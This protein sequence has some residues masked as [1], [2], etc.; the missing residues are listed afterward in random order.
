MSVP[1]HV[2]VIQP[3]R[4]GDLSNPSDI[5]TVA[6]HATTF[7]IRG[8]QNTGFGLEDGDTVF[9][10]LTC[11]QFTINSP[12]QTSPMSLSNISSSTTVVVLP[13]QLETTVE[14]MTRTL[15]ACFATG[16]ANTSINDYITL[17]D[18]LLI[19]PNPRLGQGGTI[20]AV[21]SS[22]AD[23]VIS[24][25]DSG[26]RI[27]F[28]NESCGTPP[29]SGTS[30]TTVVLN[31]TV[32]STSSKVSLPDTPRLRAS[33]AFTQRTLKACFA[34]A[35]SDSTKNENW[36]ELVD[37]LEVF[38]DPSSGLT[39]LWTQGNVRE[40]SFSQPT[41]NAAQQS[42]IIVL[43]QGSCDGVHLVTMQSA[44][45]TTSAPIVLSSGAIANEFPLAS[46]K[47]N[48]LGVGIFKVCFATGS[49]G[50]DSQSDFSTLAA[51]LEI[52]ESLDATAPVFSLPQSILLGVDLVATWAAS[53][54][55]EVRVASEGSWIGLYKV[56]QCN[57][58][59]EWK[60]RCYVAFRD[61][62]PG[63]SG[64]DIRFSFADYQTAGKFELRYFR[65]DSRN[66]QGQECKGLT[67]TT[68]GVY[69]QC[70]LVAAATSDPVHIMP[71]IETQHDFASVAG[72]EHV[73][74]V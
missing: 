61:L 45:E 16:Q 9:F 42:D 31:S 4:L 25:F 39:T 74:L 47:V 41:N 14:G 24:S 58:D 20:R 2:K 54:E 15:R 70:K 33:S 36:I 44:S 65:G 29:A 34:G 27:F 35:G 23:F 6:Q 63:S 46:G 48:E 57:E 51:E 3:P 66:G 43:Q 56:G 5:R 49:S 12:N 50:G 37:V 11:E 52:Q 26:D 53:S 19:I 7:Y 72:L 60:H 18:S 32:T 64:G 68:A 13:T 40:L 62:A 73:V 1:H 71:S 55:L 59:N 28:H 69:L 67:G 10:A 30:S 8:S 38:P 21:D 17:S 22:I